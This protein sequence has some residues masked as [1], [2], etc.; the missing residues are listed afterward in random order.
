MKRLIMISFAVMAV[1]SSCVAAIFV[2]APRTPTRLRVLYP[3]GWITTTTAAKPE[4]PTACFK[5]QRCTPA[6]LK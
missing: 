4:L 3:A 5:R 2:Q 6:P 1:S